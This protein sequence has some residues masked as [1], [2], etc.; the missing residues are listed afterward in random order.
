VS[1]EV[2]VVVTAMV[3]LVTGSSYSSSISSNMIDGDNHDNVPWGKSTLLSN[4]YYIFWSYTVYQNTLI[5]F[6]RFTITFAKCFDINPY[7]A[8]VENMVSS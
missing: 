6:V 4:Y 8:N 7:P 5:S 2:V 3:V 1:V